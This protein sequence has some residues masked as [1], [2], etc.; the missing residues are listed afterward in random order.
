MSQL[1]TVNRYAIVVLPTQAYLDWANTCPGQK[2]P[3]TLEALR[4]EATVYLI[5]ATGDDLEKSLRRHFKSIFT[6]ELAAW[7][8][9]ENHWPENLSFRTFRKFF[10]VHVA[11]MVFDLAKGPI[12]KEDEGE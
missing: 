1:A 7:Y 8:R 11:S 9:D 12:I 4:R 3:V 2:P 5:P 6:E 10:D